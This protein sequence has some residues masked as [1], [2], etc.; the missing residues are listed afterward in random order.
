[1]GSVKLQRFDLWI[2]R[3]QMTKCAKITPH[4]ELPGSKEEVLLLALLPW[5]RLRGIVFPF[6]RDLESDFLGQFDQ[7]LDEFMSNISIGP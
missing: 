5:M 6:D 2:P 1:M 3:Y 7:H 4:A